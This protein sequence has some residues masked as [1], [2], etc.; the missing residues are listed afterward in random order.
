M[1]VPGSTKMKVKPTFIRALLE[2]DM[3]EERARAQNVD[4]GTARIQVMAHHQLQELYRRQLLQLTQ[5]GKNPKPHPHTF[6]KLNPR[7]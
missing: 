5:S 3:V 1:K 7:E 6:F 2:V 4:V